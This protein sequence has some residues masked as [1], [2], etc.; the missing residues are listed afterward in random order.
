MLCVAGLMVPETIRHG[1]P[2]AKVRTWAALVSVSAFGWLVTPE[3][4]RTPFLAYNLL[5][6]AGAWAVLTHPAGTAQRAIGMIL[7]AMAVFHFGAAWSGA[8]VG[9]DVYYDV[10]IAGGWAQVAILAAWV[11]RDGFGKMV[12]SRLHRFRAAPNNPFAGKA[13]K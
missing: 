11:V 6:F 7:A 4:G 1:L 8:A 5:C 9:S 10:L 2:S 3:T 12:S 13:R